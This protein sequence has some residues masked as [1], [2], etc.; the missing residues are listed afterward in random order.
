M[1]KASRRAARQRTTKVGGDFDAAVKLANVSTYEEYLQ[2]LRDHPSIGTS[3]TLLEVEA[4]VTEPGYGALFEALVPLVRGAIDGDTKAAWAAYEPMLRELRQH[5]ARAADLDSKLADAGS[6]EDW[7]LV[8]EIGNELVRVAEA[9]GLGAAVSLAA[10]AVGVAWL[11]REAQDRAAA[12][13]RSGE[14]LDLAARTAPTGRMRA[15]A[16]MHLALAYGER[17]LGERRDNLE[18]AIELLELAL[19][20]LETEPEPE[21]RAMIETNL[22]VTLGRSERPDVVQTARRCRD[23]CRAALAVRSAELNA[24]DWAYSQINLGEALVTLALHGE[25]SSAA[26]RVLDEVLRRSDDIPDKLVSRAHEA[27]ARLYGEST[28]LSPE[29]L[30]ELWE[31]TGTT[32][33]PT[34]PG[35]RAKALEHLSAAVD[36]CDD[37]LH[38]ARLRARAADIQAD[39]GHDEAA[40]EN[41]QLALEVLTPLNAPYACRD[42]AR[43]LA[44]VHSAN[45]RWT[46]AAEAYDT[47]IDAMSL[48]LDVREYVQT[49]ES[50]MQAA[51]NLHRWAA[52]AQARAGRHGDAVVTLESG[53]AR[54]LRRRMPDQETEAL[55]KPLQIKYRAALNA[56]RTAP[57]GTEEKHSRAVHAVTR[58][59]REHAGF[60]TYGLAPTLEGIRAAA[61]PGWPVIYVNPTPAGTVLLP[62]SQEYE[63]M[64]PVLLPCRSDEIFT[65]LLRYLLYAAEGTESSVPEGALGEALSTLLPWLG[66][67]LAG[68]VASLAE[69]LDAVGLT[70]ILC[71][72]VTLAP[73]AA[74]PLPQ[75]VDTTLADRFPTRLAPS[76]GVLET[77]LHREAQRT[78]SEPSLVAVAN[79]TRDLPGA[80]N[81]ATEI[82]TFFPGRSEVAIGRD[83]TATFLQAKIAGA[84]HVHLACHGRTGAF[85][86]A[87]AQLTL[88]DGPLT[89]AQLSQLGSLSARLVALSA[90]QTAHHDV[91]ATSG[92]SLS[93]ATAL[94]PLGASCVLAS[95]W[96]VSDLSTAYLMTEFYRQHIDLERSPAVALANAQ[97][98][99]RALTWDEEQRL[100]TKH[101]AL[102]ARYARLAANGALPGNRSDTASL[103]PGTR[104]AFRDPEHWAGFIAIGC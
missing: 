102:A 75:L 58:E 74:A 61:A 42:A 68:P 82:A 43:T 25:E 86:L 26:E 88:A 69:S 7:P 46:E 41:A 4:R 50:E 5:Q 9:G 27:L 3:A 29:A 65:E 93:L 48:L 14:A 33:D 20:E 21:L 79:P 73:L 16:L 98:W 34:A 90:C 8:I 71:G 28:T 99:L 37:R 30:L 85:D 24:V 19:A 77:S 35:L 36:L 47:A 80:E 6:Q 95:L 67:T 87:D 63:S 103:A 38:A 84:S 60:E 40:S 54:E 76:A 53:L 89:V 23:L 66:E 44:S 32:E 31:Q 97:R 81:E 13:E 91:T 64:S 101:P 1:G 83:A 11:N 22:A 96:P 39:L 17:I 18:Q 59:I 45:G 2:I 78:R 72:P 70:L 12:L 52:Y 57:A 100:L 62:V 49:R 10:G 51:G 92:E 15:S 104:P 55:P 56:L 94:L